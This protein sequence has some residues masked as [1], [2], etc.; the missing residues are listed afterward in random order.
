M[1]DK[2][3]KTTKVE[4]TKEEQKIAKKR[5]LATG[6]GMTFTPPAKKK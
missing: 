6:E 1:D 2:K 4:K 5:F 3:N